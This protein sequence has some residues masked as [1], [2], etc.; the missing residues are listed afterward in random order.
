MLKKVSHQPTAGLGNQLTEDLV[1]EIMTY[2]GIKFPPHA[3]VTN[4]EE[5]SEKAS[6]LGFPLA[7]KIVSNQILHKTELQGVKTQLRCMDEVL[8]AYNDMHS[9]LSQ[10]YPI[11]GVLL[12][13]MAS[14]GVELI[15]GLQNDVTFG[16]IIMLGLGGIY[17]E[18]LKDV[19]F[20]VLPISR[21][22]ALEMLESLK[23]SSILK[24]YRGSDGVS[25][26]MLSELIVKIGSLGMELAPFIESIDF[27]P[28]IVYPDDYCVVD[29]KVLLRETFEDSVVSEAQPNSN[30]V[31]L[32]FSAKSVAVIGASP[33]AGKIGNCILKSIKR[34]YSGKVFPVNAEGYTEIMGLRAFRSLEHIEE[35]VD[36]AVVI[37]DLKLVPD[38]VKS[39]A[40]RNI[41]NMIVLTGG[42]KEL[43]DEGA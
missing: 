5:C 14:P 41:R 11:K 42:G 2:Y 36:L 12:E 22:D 20:R 8:D 21:Q 7:A 6:K 43:G 1:R 26:D 35:K 28:V 19:S 17:T 13:H 15:I 3:L 30:F 39:C 9:R 33:D 32:F 24:G 40:S 29:A 37:V 4:I 16:P 38:L 31:D 25:L 10:D 23:G 18:V 27:N 34:K